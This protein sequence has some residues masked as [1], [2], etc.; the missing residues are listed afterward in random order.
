MFSKADKT[1]HSSVAVQ[2][3]AQQQPAFFRKAGEE[4]F[5]GNHEQ[6]QPSFFSAAIQA[7][8]TVSSPDDP[9]E[10]E[11]DAVAD[12]VMR[13]PE[14]TVM[15]AADKPAVQEEEKVQTKPTGDIQAREEEETVQPKIEAP[16]I[17]TIARKEKEEQSL[18]AKHFAGIYRMADEGPAQLETGT[19]TVG[20]T[21]GYINRKNIGLY[22]SDTIQRSGRGPP[23]GQ[24]PF[25]QSLASS[26]GGGSALPVDTRE[27]MESRFNA[28]FS[29]VRIHTG[30]EARSMSS[31]IHAQAFAHGN[32]IY[33]N[34]GKYAPHTEGGKTLLAHELTH[35]I[36]QGA[37]SVKGP[38]SAVSP[39][40]IARKNMVQRSEGGVP[41]QL[42][43]AV[44]K[45]KTVEGK[46]DANKPGPDGNRTGWQ[47]LVE[48]F[49]TTFGEDKIVSGSGS[50]VQGAVAEQDIKQKRMAAGAV[51]D[52]TSQ[53]HRNAVPTSMPGT[54]DAMP[55]WCGIFVFWA[56]NKSGVPMP[57]W[58]LGER[59]IPL[60]AARPPG[61]APL[62]GDIAYRNAFSHFAIVDKVAGNTVTTVNGNT[63]G[64]DNLGGQ[65]QTKDHPL[66]EWTAFFNPLQVM[67]GQLGSGE[68][69]V[70]EKPKT[71]REMRQELFNVNRKPEAEEEQE[72]EA[73]Q[74]K[75]DAPESEA[76][77]AAPELGSMAVDAKG[78]LTSHPSSASAN[79]AVQAKPTAE[80]TAR[81]EEN[82]E[83]K[84]APE[85]QAD[86]KLLTKSMIEPEVR[87]PLPTNTVGEA[88]APGT[89]VAAATVVQ[90]KPVGEEEL[91]AKEEEP[92]EESSTVRT[93]LQLKNAEASLHDTTIQQSHGKTAGASI[94]QP[95]AI[96]GGNN[97]SLTNEAHG[98]GAVAEVQG[99][100]PPQVVQRSSHVIQRGWFDDAVSAVGGAI[101]GAIDLVA[102]GLEAGKRWVLEQ[103]QELA[104]N[105]PGYLAL[106][107]VLGSDP[108]SGAY[109]E[110]NGHNFI[111]AA[112]DIMPGG[113]LLHQKLSELGALTEAEIWVDARI[114]DIT[115]LVSGVVARV[116]RFFNSLSLDSLASPTQVLEDAGRIIY[117]TIR[118]IVN[119]AINAAAELL[120]IV[121][122]WLLD[123]VVGFI[124]ERTT[125]YP[126][127]CVILGQ[128][129]I[130]EQPVAR[131]GTNILNAILE[132]GGEEGIQ[133]RN[134]MQETG[135]FQRVA[136][137][138]DEGIVVFGD[139][140][141]AIRNGF[142][143]IWSVVSIDA[144]M[145]PIDTF[146]RI[147]DTFAAPVLRVLAFM[148]RVAIEI[149]RLIKEVL[150][151][152]LSAWARGTRGYHLVT[153][154]I[155][156]DP[157]TD[158]RVPRTIPNII[159]GFM[160]L[161]DGGEEQY[162]QM[163]ESGAI[164][165]TTQRI[166]A[167]VARLNMTPAS[168]VQ[169][170]IDLWNS[171]SLNDL[172]NPIAAFRRIIATFGEPI[173]R[174]IAFVVEIVKIVV[175][176]ILEIMNFPFDLIN[177]IITRSMAAF[178]RI[179]RDPI[180]FLKNLLRAIK[181][182]FIQFFDNIL[183]HLMN[184]V[185]G[186]LMAELRD[187]NVPAPTDFSLRGIIG[188]VLQ[189]LGISMEAIWAKLA[190]HPRIGPERVAR[191]RSMINTLE[192]IWTFIRDVQERGI[193]AIW[194]R[195]QE[196]LSNLWNTVLDAVK[197]WI[198]E[199][200]VTQMTARL[201]SMLDPT[202]IMAVINSAIAI[203]RAIQSFIRYLRQML[204][205]VNSFVNG[206]ADIA[207]GNVSTAANY[208][209]STMGRAMPIVI[210]FLA[211]Q[212][213]LS[214]I[215]RRIAEIIGAVREM[216]DRALTWLVNRAV[217]TGFAI[218]DRLMAMG[219]SAVAAGR[220]MI[221]NFLNWWRMRKPFRASDGES[222]TL[223]YDGNAT[224][225]KLKVASNPVDVD[226]FIANS[227]TNLSTITDASRRN[228]ME[229][230]LI[231]DA[232]A[233]Y[234]VVVTKE[235]ALKAVNNRTSTANQNLP[236]DD[237]QT[238][239]NELEQA[240][241][242]LMPVLG[243]MMVSNAQYPPMRLP[244]YSNNV[245]PSGATADYFNKTRLTAAGM[246]HV[247]APSNSNLHRGN[248]EGWTQLTNARLAPPYARV[249]LFTHRFGGEPTDSNLVPADAFAVNNKM[250]AMET[251]MTTSLNAGGTLWYNCTVTLG[252]VVNI[253]GPYRPSFNTSATQRY[254]SNINAQ[255]GTYQPKPGSATEFDK[256]TST[257]V[258]N[259]SPGPPV[260]PA[261]GTALTIQLF[262]AGRYAIN[263]VLGR[264]ADAAIGRNMAAA[265]R[266][267]PSANYPNVT[268]AA[269]LVSELALV[270][271]TLSLADANTIV[272]NIPALLTVPLPR[273]YQAG[274]YDLNDMLGKPQDARIG[275]NL[276]EALRLIPAAKYSNVS[277][278]ATL[279]AELAAVGFT[280]SPADAATIVSNI[281]SRF[282][283]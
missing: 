130:T 194:E 202:G 113:R 189:V 280:L 111:E 134:Q 281:P 274:R 12:Q 239:Y 36:Q 170:F 38:G 249:H 221:R 21:S 254:L 206:V 121:K 116:E 69:A 137:Y 161:M 211:N 104:M 252:N 90:T 19:G 32:D 35:T 228:E 20:I 5:F 242:D 120:A 203:Y 22:R 171:F 61:M 44:T 23:T 17:R 60:E 240:I 213:G 230:I 65:V 275:R 70:E 266:L 37:S 123:Q 151:Q 29:G 86:A 64:E 96:A 67:Q 59:M 25:E 82:S 93:K 144:L 264:T 125:A 217:D 271:F 188:W 246:W 163:V 68:G 265:L 87:Q 183:T 229:T 185:V 48:I 101:S 204:E 10:K 99:R 118:D 225:A 223:Y 71:L 30:A 43:N 146:T 159:R 55:S 156:K 222:H 197:N 46:I 107:V 198:M 128:D 138:I 199:R 268:N 237:N 6:A 232:E 8:L 45:A 178:H 74:R 141:A 103:A 283:Y 164:E 33:F 191:L 112:F 212:V 7:K 181:Q 241:N 50:S 263:S 153:V 233:K 276:S 119:F 106:R 136:A 219:R 218:F 200:I 109:V 15:A 18:Q 24:I 270:G 231:P 175:M 97:S 140:L 157:F 267:I 77:Q 158:E 102:E 184:G 142:S 258:V 100:G 205:V 63:A 165:R 11:A 256:S 135:T 226:I 16:L 81:E 234:N 195:I 262:Q 139:L 83:E 31:D 247:G 193:A 278:A 208:L 243:R 80:P 236:T 145:H 88:P 214:G 42:T 105:I 72:T 28:D 41:V 255:W 2:Q 117:D 13:M 57:K 201:L 279:I 127:L 207:E 92:K 166:H 143:V 260:F 14:P 259:E 174:L 110:R 85:G 84:A 131:N 190:A 40:T 269:T 155:G 56:L 89:A 176:V 79:E 187:A 133:Q 114:A 52:T 149:L 75:A 182:G 227:R 277:S 167:A 78:S 73:V 94:I 152:R 160:S 91:Q 168:I 115:S 177:N 51:V 235:T 150:M 244:S 26:K 53:T 179:K 49:K 1:S 34:D 39:K 282:T 180:G 147:Y 154:L 58:K 4:T 250:T 9:Q 251:A 47:H 173:A 210:G 273:I 253:P 169:L 245:L 238:Q 215:G 54:R 261:P 95:Q 122:R 272:N 124:R 76:A 148:A 129:P 98:T 186:W 196:Q 3:K 132:L 209:E 216:V 192:G 62:P 220:D 172:A 224:N 248:L 162:Q 126:L 108:I 66:A 27:F 257:D